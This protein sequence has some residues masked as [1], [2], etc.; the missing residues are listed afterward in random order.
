[1]NSL[2][3][4]FLYATLYSEPLT[5]LWVHTANLKYIS[6]SNTIFLLHNLKQ[7]LKYWTLPG[8]FLRVESRISGSTTTLHLQRG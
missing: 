5:R 7:S 8:I 4:I 6:H 2:F 3:K 1:M